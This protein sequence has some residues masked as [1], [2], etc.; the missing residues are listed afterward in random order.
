MR[1]K[2]IALAFTTISAL[3]NVPS[4]FAASLDTTFGDNG[5]V[6]YHYT[7][8]N[9]FRTFASSSVIQPDG[10]IIVAGDGYISQSVDGLMVVRYNSNGT[11]DNTFGINGVAKFDLGQFE[12]VVR[13][14]V[15]SDGKILVGG[16]RHSGYTGGDF[17]VLRLNNDGSF[18]NTFDGNG[19]AVA[20][21]DGYSNEITSDM[22]LLPSGK[23][24]LVGSSS[25][26]NSNTTDWAAARMNSDG[27]VDT[28]FGTSGFI[29]APTTDTQDDVAAAALQADGKLLLC[30]VRSNGSNNDITLSRFSGNGAPDTSFG[31]G[32]TVQYSL[33]NGDDSCSSMQVQ[34]DG[35][36][37]VGGVSHLDN[38]RFVLLRFDAGGTLD[39]TFGTMG[40]A[41]PAGSGIVAGSI[42]IQPDNKIVVQSYLRGDAIVLRFGIDGRLDP[43]FG[44]GGRVTV[45]VGHIYHFSPQ[46]GTVNIQADGNIVISGAEINTAPGDDG[47]LFAARLTQDGGAESPFDFDGD[48]RTDISVFRPESGVW[49]VKRSSD[50]FLATQ[51]GLAIDRPVSADYDGDGKADIAVF[52]D[53]VWYWL[54]SSDNVFSAVGFGFASDT[55]VPADYTGDGRAELAVY[56]SGVWFTLNTL[57]NGYGVYSFG[58]PT[59]KPVPADFDG[60]RKAD[61]AVFRDGVWYVQG[62]TV[63][64]GATQFGLAGDKPVVG[65]YDGD[66]KADPAVYRG[67]VWY[68]LGSRQGFFAQSFGLPT[69]IPVVGD[70]DGDGKVDP[71]VY[72]AGTWYMNGTMSGFS[73]AAFGLSTDKPV[74]AAFVP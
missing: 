57:D 45:R 29:I 44:N 7:T 61:Y 56:R 6:R 65:D 43:T 14:L 49:Y 74:P 48:G 8:A 62:T 13:V 58:L 55:P 25:N 2:I 54:R 28:S 47:W 71:S 53:G 23:I 72:R 50:G 36:I 68:M 60:D 64:F 32:G 5:L 12:S 18:D 26:G 38:Y 21:L 30:G 22:L 35:K 41:M 66:R 1:L 4:F 69:D 39:Q 70:F 11:L 9:S 24:I 73:V 46:V 17:T 15:Q 33:G 40:V 31:S 3:L 20:G 16:T 42:A 59:D 10:K 37:V 63:G 67:G 19:V 27:S 51:F 34:P 52:R